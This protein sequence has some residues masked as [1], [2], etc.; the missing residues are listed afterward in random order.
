MTHSHVDTICLLYPSAAEKTFLMREFDDT[1]DTF[2]KD[3]SD[4]IGGSYEVY[5]N[6]RDQIEQGIAS[7]L[8]FLEKGDTAFFGAATGGKVSRVAIA[9]DHGGFELKKTLKEHLEKSGLSVADF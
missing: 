7:I 2:E 8:R 5:V 1:L 6:C 4:P 9:A 3:V